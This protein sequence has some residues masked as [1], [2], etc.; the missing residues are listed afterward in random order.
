MAVMEQERQEEVSTIISPLD[1]AAEM[2]CLLLSMLFDRQTN[3]LNDL[4]PTFHA[5]EREGKLNCLE[6]V[7]GMIDAAQDAGSVSGTT[8]TRSL[9]SAFMISD[10]KIVPH[11]VDSFLSLLLQRE[12]PGEFR[13]LAFKAAGCYVKGDSLAVIELA[14][15]LA[16]SIEIPANDDIS[17]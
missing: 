11:E 8:Q 2:F 12:N 15:L 6:C 7:L 5:L 17:F 9:I 13:R 3:A 10:M 16:E 4:L 14:E 1:T